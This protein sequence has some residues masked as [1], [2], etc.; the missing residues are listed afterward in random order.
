VSQCVVERLLRD[1]VD[2]LLDRFGQ[3]DIVESGVGG[4]AGALLDGRETRA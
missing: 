3:P 2:L 4:Q 1:A